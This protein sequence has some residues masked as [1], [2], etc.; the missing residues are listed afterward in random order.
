MGE[1][2]DLRIFRENHISNQQYSVSAAAE[3]FSV[4]DLHRT[5]KKNAMNTR[6]LIVVMPDS[7]IRGKKS[8]G[9][10]TAIANQK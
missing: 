4:G 1:V 9:I 3:I 2:F 7:W 5:T 6:M 8:Q 10:K